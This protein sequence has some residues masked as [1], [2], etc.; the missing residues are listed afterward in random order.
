MWIYLVS[1]VMLGHRAITDYSVQMELQKKLKF[2]FWSA[3]MRPLI[4]DSLTLLK[5]S[6]CLT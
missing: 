5:Q 6:K 4:C 1:Y 2:Y 3:E